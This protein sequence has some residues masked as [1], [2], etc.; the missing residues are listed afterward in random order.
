MSQIPRPEQ[1]EVV[2][3]QYGDTVFIRLSGEFDIAGEEH[4]DR[5]LQQAEL[6]A[7]SVVIDLSDLVFID[8]SGLRALLRVW[9]RASEDGHDLVMVPGSEQVRRTMELTG[10]DSVLPLAERPPLTPAAPE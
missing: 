8:S 5:T 9:R 7:Q 3:E 1:F 10:V 2:S 6:R 4:F